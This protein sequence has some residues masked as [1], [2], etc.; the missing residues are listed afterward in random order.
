MTPYEMMSM[1][2]GMTKL[3]YST[4][5]LHGLSSQVVLDGSRVNSFLTSSRRISLLVKLRNFCVVG[6]DCPMLDSSH[7]NG[8]IHSGVIMLTYELI[9]EAHRQVESRLTIIVNNTA[10]KPL[11]LQ[12][13]KSFQSFTFAY[14]ISAFHILFASED[15]VKFTTGIVVRQLPPGVDR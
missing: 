10:D 4:S 6:N 11:L 5:D 12:S 1:A 3:T 8:Y 13:G 7:H 15:I 2:R 9:S 14:P